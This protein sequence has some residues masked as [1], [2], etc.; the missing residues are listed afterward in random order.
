MVRGQRRI[1]GEIAYGNAFSGNVPEEFPLDDWRH[2]NAAW[3]DW[4]NWSGSK[5]MTAAFNKLIRDE[6][7]A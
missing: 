4:R 7:N 6:I 5:E 3:R 2:P 1:G